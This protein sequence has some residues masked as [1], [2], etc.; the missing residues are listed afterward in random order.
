MK[1]LC[2]FW[3]FLWNYFE[4][5]VNAPELFTIMCKC[6]WMI[7]NMC[8]ASVKAAEFTQV[9]VKLPELIK[10][11]ANAPEYLNCC[12]CGWTYLLNV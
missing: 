5:G 6:D 4:F 12:E 1:F 9:S 7:Y 8:K 10:F 2:L 3:A 11:N